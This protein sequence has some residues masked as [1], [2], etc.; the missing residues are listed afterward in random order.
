[1]VK[2]QGNLFYFYFYFYIIIAD[3]EIVHLFCKIVI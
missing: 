3:I 1:M 2:S